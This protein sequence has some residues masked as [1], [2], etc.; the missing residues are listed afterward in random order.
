MYQHNNLSQF[1]NKKY[2]KTI[3]PKV[4]FGKNCHLFKNKKITI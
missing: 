2:A 3:S 4:K 1:P